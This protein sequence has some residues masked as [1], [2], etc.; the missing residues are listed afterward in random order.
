M[1]LGRTSATQP[2]SEPAEPLD[3]ALERISEMT[4]EQVRACW[5]ETTSSDPP[6]AFSKDLLARAIGY[7]L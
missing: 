1:A 3:A 2:A 6:P 5:R 4:V 7:R